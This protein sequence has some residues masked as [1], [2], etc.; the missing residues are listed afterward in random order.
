MMSVVRGGV[1]TLIVCFADSPSLLEEN[2]PELT[3][4]IVTAWAEAFPE[5]ISKHALPQT[6]STAVAMSVVP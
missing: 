4:E 5:T 1:N 2:H 3:Q 6:T